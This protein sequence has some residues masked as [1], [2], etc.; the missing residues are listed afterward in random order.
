MLQSMQLRSFCPAP[1]RPADRGGGLQQPRPPPPGAA[2]AGACPLH[3]RVTAGPTPT[4]TA[5]TLAGTV[6]GRPGDRPGG[7][8]GTRRTGR[9]RAVPGVPPRHRPA[10]QPLSYGSVLRRPNHAHACDVHH[11]GEHS[12]SVRSKQ[13]GSAVPEKRCSRCVFDS[14]LCVYRSVGGV[15]WACS[16]AQPSRSVEIPSRGP[17]RLPTLDRLAV[18]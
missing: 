11:A 15:R 6:G 12:T 7:A 4:S 1:R 14:S 9:H 8:S 17:P 3:P 18:P 2:N 10:A 16:E 5:P 13:G